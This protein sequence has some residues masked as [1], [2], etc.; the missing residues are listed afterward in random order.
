MSFALRDCT[1]SV[2]CFQYLLPETPFLLEIYDAHVVCARPHHSENLNRAHVHIRRT[3]IRSTYWPYNAL[4]S[5]FREDMRFSGTECSA[6][7][8]V[9][10]TFPL[11]WSMT[12]YSELF[13]PTAIHLRLND[14][15]KDAST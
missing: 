11:E 6:V 5:S 8:F 2:V 7:A 12:S 10:V 13:T 3:E 9:S 14:T 15:S 1:G 4:T